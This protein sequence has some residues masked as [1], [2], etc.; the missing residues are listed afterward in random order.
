MARAARELSARVAAVY[1]DT[2]KNPSYL[3]KQL[4]D[5]PFVCENYCQMPRRLGIK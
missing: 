1:R 4:N 3:K 2:A 5:E